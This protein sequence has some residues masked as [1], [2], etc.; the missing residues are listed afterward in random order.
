MA[1]SGGLAIALLIILAF[2]GFGLWAKTPRGK[3]MME[4]AFGAPDKGAKKRPPPRRS[5]AP[6]AKPSASKTSN[7]K[8][9]AAK[10]Q[11]PK[12]PAAKPVRKPRS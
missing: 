8:P 7:A 4:E 11:T 3:Q 9:T 5:P 12:Q 10:E 6:S 2:A 1:D